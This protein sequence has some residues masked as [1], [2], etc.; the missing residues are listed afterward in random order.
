MAK[1]FPWRDQQ[2]ARLWVDATAYEPEMRQ[3]IERAEHYVLIE[4]YLMES[5]QVCNRVIPVLIAA[6]QRGVQ[7]LLLLDSYGSAAL[8]DADRRRLVEAGVDL[9]WFNPLRWHKLGR[10]LVRDHRKLIVVDGHTAFVGGFGWADEFETGEVPWHEVA[11]EIQGDCVGDWQTLFW[12][13]WRQARAPDVVLPDPRSCQGEMSEHRLKGRVVHAQG[14]YL[15]VVKHSLLYR[16]RHAQH[17][18]WIATPYFVPTRPIRRALIAA[19]QRGVDVRLLLPG[20]HHDHPW[21][22]LAGQQ[23]YQRLLANGV[24]IYEY[25][26]RFIHA[27]VSRVDDWVSVGSCNFDHWGLRWNREANQELEGAD[28]AWPVTEWFQSGFDQGQAID[29]QRWA[30]RSRWQKI[31][32]AFWGWVN[33]LMMK[34]H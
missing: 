18:A 17:R 1:P 8:N 25:Q 16:L 9:G 4:L 28:A 31:Q 5:G 33:G 21:I 34:L 26:P 29:P 24:R 23:F 19:A 13:S 30:Q 11:M 27:K 32:Q 3:R 10:N 2:Q 14:V 15:Q 22:R 12:R 6:A 7:V 20:P